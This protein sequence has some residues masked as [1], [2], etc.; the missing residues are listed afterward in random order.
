MS[1]ARKKTFRSSQ[2]RLSPHVPGLGV[3][4]RRNESFASPRPVREQ[5]TSLWG[6]RFESA[7]AAKAFALKH[8]PVWYQ[9]YGRG[10]VKRLDNARVVEQ[11]FFRG[12]C[13]EGLVLRK[14]G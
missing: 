1:Y 13:V 14:V 10:E 8:L 4:A 7:E 5:F 6:E 3:S 9:W 12:I 2:N 11:F